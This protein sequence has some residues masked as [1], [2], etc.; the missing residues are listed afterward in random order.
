MKAQLRYFVKDPSAI[1][2]VAMLLVIIVLA[3]LAPVLGQDPKVL[4]PS[5]RLQAPSAEFPL[6]TDTDGRDLWTML[7]YG[8][9]TSLLIAGACTVLAVIIGFLIGT[10]AGYFRTFDAIM[11]RVIDG[12]MAFPNI[13][14][15]L[16]LVGV[17]GRG[18]VPVIVGLTIVLIPPIA[19]V[20]RSAALGVKSTAMVESA[21]S[22]GAKDGWI[23]AKY[24]APEST[25]V[26]IVQTTMGFA[27]T[28][29]SIAALSFLGVGLPPDVP[30]WGTTL[31]AAQ[32]YMQTAWWMAVFPGVAIL[33]TVLALILIGDGLRDAMDPRSRRLLELSKLKRVARRAGKR[34]AMKASA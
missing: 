11:M 20:V 22:I 12:M 33:V 29:L 34:D 28:V 16:S 27:Q 15:V 9:Q 6:G 7:L 31:S 25:S 17:L 32:Q 4:D 21:R 24:V 3:L 18:I 30:S 19:R 10:T 8:A 26:L 5:S 13:I 2:G 23:L 1:V 14:L